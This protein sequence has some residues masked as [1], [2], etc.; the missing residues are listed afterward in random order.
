M[1]EEETQIEPGDLI[2]ANNYNK[3][4]LGVTYFI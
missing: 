1:I 3:I 2:I 4:N